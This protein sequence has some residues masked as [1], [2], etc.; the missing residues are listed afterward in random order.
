MNSKQKKTFIRVTSFYTLFLGLAIAPSRF[1]APSLAQNAPVCQPSV[2]SRLQTHQVR[3]G[4]TL[5]AI[6][7]QYQIFPAIILH[8]NPAWQNTQPTTGSILYI[9]PLNGIEVSTPS[10]ATWQDLADAYGVR[11]DVLFELNGCQMPGETVFIPGTSWS[12]HSVPKASNYVGLSSYPLRDRAAIGLTYGWHS[13]KGTE[14]NEFHNGIDLLAPVGT[15][16]LAA[17][18]GIIAFADRQG[19]YGNLAVINHEGGRQTRYA[20]LDT[21]NVVPGQEVQAGAILGTVGTSGKPDI[22]QPHLHFEV[23]YQVPIG[24]V[25]QDPEIHLILANW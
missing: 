13:Q 17:E 19:N 4:E 22:P 11:A 2:L 23:R 25:A 6:A 7:A 18:A 3:A 9:P 12:T 21:L 14:E 15:S 16:V 10:G 24:W 8:F 5:D 20:H 1:L